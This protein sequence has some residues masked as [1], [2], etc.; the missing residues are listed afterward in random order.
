MFLPVAWRGCARRHVGYAQEEVDVEA[1]KKVLPYG[2][3][4]P[5][6]FQHGGMRTPSANIGGKAF[7]VVSRQTGVSTSVGVTG[8]SS[9]YTGTGG[10][11]RFP[12]TR[13]GRNPCKARLRK[14]SFGDMSPT[15]P[16]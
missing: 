14:R 16:V 1:I 7:E 6:E 9:G 10:Y 11:C 2:E 5:I 4:L 3:L 13:K 12:P 15:P 8:V